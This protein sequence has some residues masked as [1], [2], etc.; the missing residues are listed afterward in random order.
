MSPVR[1]SA[2]EVRSQADELAACFEGFDPSEAHEVPVAEYL[3]ERAMRARTLCEREVARAVIVA[4]TG[5]ATWRR[6][7]EVLGVDERD[8]RE[9][10]GLDE[11]QRA[12]VGATRTPEL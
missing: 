3:L 10:Y 11:D 12:E 1:R 7:G 6:I 5:G 9:A 2:E 4:R 8:A